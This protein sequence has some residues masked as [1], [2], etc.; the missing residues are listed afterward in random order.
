MIA[1]GLFILWIDIKIKVNGPTA[2]PL[3]IFLQEHSSGIFGNAIKW[4]FTKFLIDAEGN[5]VKRFAP[6]ISPA[7]IKRDIEKLIQK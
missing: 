6:T 7:K 1:F 5:V 2:H 4:N 3:Y